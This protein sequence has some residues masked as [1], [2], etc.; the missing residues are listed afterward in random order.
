MNI[1]LKSCIKSW[2]MEFAAIQ[3]KSAYRAGAARSAPRRLL[4]VSSSVTRAPSGFCLCSYGFNRQVQELTVLC[5]LCVSMVCLIKTTKTQKISK[6]AL[7]IQVQQDRF[8]DSRQ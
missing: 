4:K 8:L 6:A 2:R 7:S 5:A 1:E 3:T